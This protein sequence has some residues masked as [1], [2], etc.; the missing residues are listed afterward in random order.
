MLVISIALLSASA[1]AQTA[2]PDLAAS[3]PGD[4]NAGFA[5]QA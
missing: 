4:P 3:L 1:A 2:P 5:G